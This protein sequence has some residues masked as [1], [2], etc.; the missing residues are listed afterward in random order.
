MSATPAAVRI[1]EES[2]PVPG[3]APVRAWLVAADDFGRPRSGVLW[4]H[5]LGHVR[6]DRG[7]FLPLAVDLAWRGVVSLLPAGQFPWVTDPDGTAEDV[8]RVRAQVDACA[9]ALDHLAAQPGLG[10]ARIAVVG[11]DYG[12]M[13]GALLAERDERVSALAV[14]ASDAT[15]A[16]WFAT[17]WLKLEDD[18]RA[19][20]AAGFAGLDPVE[21]VGRLEDRVLLQWAGQDTFVSEETRAAYAAA[22]PRARTHVYDSAEHQ[23]DDRA[24]VDLTAFLEQHLGLAP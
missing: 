6:N 17:Y 7:E 23:L 10:P 4:L 21:H 12:G 9:A 1:V 18:A 20:Y 16:N 22:N 3:Q 11:H 15:W 19:G 8:A 24:G 14:Q 2:L 13:Y 5:W